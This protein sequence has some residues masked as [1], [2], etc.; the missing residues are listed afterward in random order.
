MDKS[1]NINY[2]QYKKSSRWPVT[3]AVDLIR[4]VPEKLEVPGLG[5][6]EVKLSRSEASRILTL[7][8]DVTG[9]DRGRLNVALAKEYCKRYDP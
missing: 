2:E 6:I 7:I 9:Y 1:G 5:N 8:C 3:Y 4:E